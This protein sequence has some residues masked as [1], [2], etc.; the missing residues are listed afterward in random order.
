[1]N[2]AIQTLEFNKIKE[3]LSEFCQSSLGKQLVDNLYPAVNIKAVETRLKE[4]KEA[5][6]LLKAGMIPPLGGLSNI[7]M[8]LEKTEK[9]MILE[10]SELTAINDFLRACRNLEQFMNKH[11]ELIPLIS[12]YILSMKSYKYIEEEISYSVS[13]AIVLSQASKN[14]GRI[15]RLKENQKEK[16]EKTLQAFLSSNSNKSLIQEFFISEKNGHYT[17]PIKSA[18][19]NHVDGSII[20]TSSTGSTVFIEPKAISKLAGEMQMLE[21]EEMAEQYQILAGLTGLIYENISSIKQN[22]ELMATYD[23]IF[24]KARYAISINAAI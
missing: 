21:A 18:Y 23:L 13:G 6:R 10:A 1:M 24:A 22:M 17:I 3:R 5:V 16:I 2:K 20:E 4:T 14:L 19:K 15:R 12:E 8:L 7:S 9:G 11:K